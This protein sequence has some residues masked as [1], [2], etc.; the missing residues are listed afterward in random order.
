MC[1]GVN[2]SRDGDWVH[3]AFLWTHA[4]VLD[5]GYRPWVGIMCYSS[6]FHCLISLRYTA[7]TLENDTEAVNRLRSTVDA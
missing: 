7:M 5:V 6:F 4:R 2:A 1:K 3:A